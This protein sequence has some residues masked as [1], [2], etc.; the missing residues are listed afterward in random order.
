MRYLKDDCGQD[1]YP[2]SPIC[3]EQGW[4]WQ[5]STGGCHDNPVCTTDLSP[6]HD[7]GSLSRDIEGSCQSEPQGCQPLEPCPVR[8][9]CPPQQSCDSGKPRRRVE[10][11]PVP[12]PCPPPVKIHRRPLQQYRPPF[13]C[14]EPESCNKPRRRVEQ[15]PEEEPSCPPIILHPLPRQHRCPCIH[16]HPHPIQ[17]RCPVPLPPPVCPSQQQQKQKVTLLPPCLQKK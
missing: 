17:H 9:C 14:E 16:C 1:S 12:P 3:S 7:H 8:T 5:S 13:H 11:S 2:D 15:C 6:C 4:T 10:V